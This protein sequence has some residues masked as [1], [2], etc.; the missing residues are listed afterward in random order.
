MGIFQLETTHEAD[1][2]R[3]SVMGL[4]KE[5]VITREQ[6]LIHFYQC[7]SKAEDA[8]FGNDEI[9]VISLQ[10]GTDLN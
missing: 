9:R 1:E 3:K 8:S 2:M 4:F 10:V 7:P 6:L 5:C